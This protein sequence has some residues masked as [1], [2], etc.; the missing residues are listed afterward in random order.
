MK[1]YTK[2]HRKRDHFQGSG[3][4]AGQLQHSRGGLAL[5]TSARRLPG[6]TNKKRVGGQMLPVCL[7]IFYLSI[8]LS[9]YIYINLY[10]CGICVYQNICLYIHM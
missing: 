5:E 2:T 4:G 10:V 7:C 8:Y 9:I 6:K 3:G 1:K